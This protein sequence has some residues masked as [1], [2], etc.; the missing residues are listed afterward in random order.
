MTQQE[1]DGAKAVSI[2]RLK[3][4]VGERVL[5]QGW[6][7]NKRGK[8][9]LLFLQV[10][11]GSGIVQV[12]T[13]RDAVDEESFAN[14]KAA[15][16]ECSIRVIGTPVADQR[17]QGGV[18]LQPEKILIVHMPTEEYPITP[19][20]HGPGF[21][22]DRRH[23]WLRSRKQM[24]TLRIRDEVAKAIRDFFYERDFV[25]ADSPIFTPNACEGTT[26]LFEVKYFDDHAYLTQSGQLYAEASAMALGKVYTFGPTFRAEKSKTRR[27]LTEFWMIEPEAAY[28][29]LDDVMRLAEDF[30]AYVVG[31][32][33]ENRA[34]ELKQLERDTTVLEHASKTPYPRLSYEEASEMLSK[35]EGLETPWVPGEDFGAPHES[36][37]GSQFQQPVLI[38]RYPAKIKSFYMRRDP[39]S[40]EHALCVDMIAPESYGEII[41][42]SEREPD[43]ETL[44]ARIAEHGL[45]EELFSW[46]LDLRRFGSV[47]HGGF[48][49]GLERTVSWICGSQHLR[50]C[51]PFPR[52]L[53]RLA[54]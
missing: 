39:E 11:D 33:L 50:E 27:H 40:P 36:Y 19:K 42:G 23:L 25:C 4:H 10:R 54:P 21:L 13:P 45:P 48:G 32:C 18:E 1:L 15:K 38:H 46:Y 43:L 30:V 34:E 9:K 51:I 28:Y 22:M 47:P 41:G 14:A 5:V 3:D 6:L 7:Y 2:H 49:L 12:V 53:E 17:A 16:Q 29:D 31:R 37:L 8:G 35:A 26:D 20:E 52:M 44:R 24:A